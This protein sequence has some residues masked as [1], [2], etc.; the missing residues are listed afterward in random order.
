MAKKINLCRV[1]V[2]KNEGKSSFG[3][4]RIGREYNI[5]MGLK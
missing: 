5:K 1:L 4:P 2:R 3:R